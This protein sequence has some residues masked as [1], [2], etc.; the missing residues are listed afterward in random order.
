[1]IDYIILLYFSIHF[2]F[3]LSSAKKLPKSEP[4][5]AGANSGRSRGVDLTETAQPTKAPC[6]SN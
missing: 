6:C 4:Q 2:L 5:A 3:C 1:M